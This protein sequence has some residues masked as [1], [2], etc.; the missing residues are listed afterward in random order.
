MW[1]KI[2]LYKFQQIDL[3]NSNDNLIEIDKLLHSTCIVFG[4]TEYQLDNTDKKKAAKLVSKVSKIFSSDFKQQVCKRIGWYVINYD[5]SKLT[6]GQYVEL[7]YFLSNGGIHSAQYVLASVSH[8]PFFKNNAAKHRA[9]SEYFLTTPIRK[10]VGSL[11]LI[12]KNFIAFN[13]EYSTLFGLDASSNDN[14]QQE[15]L[16]NKRYGWIYCAS[17]IAEYERITL[18]Q[19]YQLPIRQAF[20]DLA[21]LKAKGKYEAEQ[22]KNTKN[23]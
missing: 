15:D 4:M 14:N 16:F 23:G 1:N 19:A 2:N 13:K 3:I 8:L 12:T 20:N 5:I 18:E 21:Y 22:L 10:V 17:Q 7:S 6:F 11:E 9:K